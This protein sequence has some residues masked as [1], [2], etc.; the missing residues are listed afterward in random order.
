MQGALA[1]VFQS[2]LR[3]GEFAFSS[4]TLGKSD[5]QRRGCWT[6]AFRQHVYSDRG[7]PFAMPRGCS[8]YQIEVLSTDRSRRNVRP[9]GHV[10]TVT[11]RIL[12]PSV[13]RRQRAGKDSATNLEYHARSRA[14]LEVAWGDPE[15]S[16]VR[17]MEKHRKTQLP[18]LPSHAWVHRQATQPFGHH[19]RDW[20]R[21]LE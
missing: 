10:E 1:T 2:R 14:T 19:H 15:G 12:R 13:N 17:S 21:A 3:C 16:S 8:R 20:V 7:S 4:I 5:G 6:I 18:S 9:R 11:A